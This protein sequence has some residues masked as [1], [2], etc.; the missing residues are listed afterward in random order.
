MIPT[1]WSVYPTLAELDLAGQEGKH[2]EVEVY[3]GAEKVRLLLN[4]KVIGEQPTGR[5]QQFKAVFTVPYAA[6]HAEGRRR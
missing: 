6:G 5:E 2:L 1:V 3:A 4:D